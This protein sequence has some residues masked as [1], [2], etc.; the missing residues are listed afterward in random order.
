MLQVLGQH[1]SLGG[2]HGGRRID[3]RLEYRCGN[4]AVGLHDQGALPLLVRALREVPPEGVGEGWEASDPRLRRPHL[5]LD[6]RGAA[7]AARQQRLLPVYPRAHLHLGATERLRPEL[8]SQ[9]D[10]RQQ[11]I[12]L[13]LIPSPSTWG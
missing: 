8:I 10:N 11:A 13:S 3:Q 6:L 1:L 5:A 9:V 2:R 4:V 7:A 12:R